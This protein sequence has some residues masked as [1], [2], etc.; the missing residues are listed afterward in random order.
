MK[1]E[2]CGQRFVTEEAENEFEIECPGLLY[3][4]FE[5]KLCG[6]CAIEAVEYHTEGVYYETCEECGCLFD[7]FEPN[8]SEMDVRDYWSESIICWECAEK[9]RRNEDDEYEEYDEEDEDTERLSVYDA[10][11]IWLSNGMDEDYCFGY[12]EEELRDALK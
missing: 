11:R 5:V 9:K 1:C 4:N 7:V 6:K 10:A 2:W 12:S 3:N 8:P